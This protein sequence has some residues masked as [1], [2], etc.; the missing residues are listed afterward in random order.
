MWS[1]G[2]GGIDESRPSSSSVTLTLESASE[3]PRA[4]CEPRDA[5]DIETRSQS[6]RVAEP[7][8]GGG[9]STYR[10][11]CRRAAVESA[12]V[13]QREDLRRPRGE[14]HVRIGGRRRVW[15]TGRAAECGTRRAAE[16]GTGGAPPT[17]GRF[18]PIADLEGHIGLKA[19]HRCGARARCLP[20]AS[21]LTTLL[22]LDASASGFRGPIE[23]RA[24][25]LRPRSTTD[26]ILGF[27]S[28]DR[29]SVERVGPP[30]KSCGCCRCCPPRR[31]ASP[32]RH[33]RSDARP[34]PR[35]SPAP[36]RSSAARRVPPRAFAA[37]L[38]F[39]QP[40]RRCSAAAWR[41]TR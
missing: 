21:K 36:A 24:H 12:A 2:G 31:C 17:A 3:R 16:F 19:E 14:Q 29:A 40:R 28:G 32:P 18:A 5:G 25:F 34:P 38:R 23:L 22:A 39:R 30:P 35:A 41:T 8:A 26:A 10:P 13:A 7:G 27:D 15:T 11:S 9:G 33:L 20:L 1:G 6:S 4:A 37:R